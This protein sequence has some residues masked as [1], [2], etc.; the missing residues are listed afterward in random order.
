MFA[1][2]SVTST[3]LA[4]PTVNQEPLGPDGQLFGGSA[5]L[6]GGHIA[7]LAAKGSHYQVIMDGV[8]GPKIDNLIFNITGQQYRI[9]TLWVNQ[10]IPVIFSKDG[11]HWAYM[12]KQSDEF[13]VML[14]GK[15]FARGP[16]NMHNQGTSLNLTFSANGQHIFWSDDDAQGNYVIVA[17]GTNGPAM[18]TLPQLIL[19]PDGSRYAYVNHNRDGTGA[20]AVVDGRQVNYFGDILQYTARNMLISTMSTPDNNTIFLLNGKPEIKAYSFNQKWF[21]DDGKQLALLITPQSGVPSFLSVNGKTV[22]GTQGLNV[23]K[24]YFSPDGNHYAALCDTK[25]GAKFMIID[26]KKGDEY[27]SISQQYYYSIGN[28]MHWRYVTWTGNKSIFDDLQ[29][30]VPGFT[31]DSSKFV[32][33]ANSNGRQFLVINDDESDAFGST[34]SPILSPV[35][36]RVGVYGVTPDNVQHIIM[37]GRNTANGT[38]GNPRIT[39]LTFSPQATHYAYVQQGSAVYLDGIAQPGLMQG[40]Y[41]FSPDEKHLAYYANGNG[42]SGVVVDGKLICTKPGMVNHIFFSPDSQ[43]IYWVSTGNLSYL[44]NIQTRDN[45][46]LYVDGKPTLHYTDNGTVMDVITDTQVTLHPDYSAD[47]TMTFIARTD[48]NLRRFHIKSDT[49][50]GT[51]LATAP[52]M[53]AN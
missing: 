13:V 50:L 42:Q 26:G 43:H 11:A 22:P 48:G 52:A 37:D 46:M 45:Y 9:E 16:I 19:S 39:E 15:E 21:S 25:T 6:K 51:L 12:A 27:P 1:L 30:P 33:V 36:S 38:I 34:L 41:I 5:S 14:D 28:D 32:Y 44:M 2:F 29:P 47:D 31:A 8:E 35:G 24:V 53:K 17:D 7:V 49:D 20:W 23:E 18:Q 3:A 4:D 40:D 10:P